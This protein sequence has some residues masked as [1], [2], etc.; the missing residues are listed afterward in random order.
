MIKTQIKCAVAVAAAFF[1][2]GNVKAQNTGE[3]PNISG[4]SSG[5]KTYTLGN[6]FGVGTSAPKA[7][8]EVLYCPQSLPNPFPGLIVTSTDACMG[9]G[10][11]T[12]G[13]GTGGTDGMAGADG[14]AVPYSILGITQNVPVQFPSGTGYHSINGSSQAP[15]I[16]ARTQSPFSTFGTTNI[17]GQETPRFIVWPNG[18]TGINTA[19]P[20]AALDVM[21]TTPNK[22]VAIFGVKS[23]YKASNPIGN[24]LVDE[25]YSKHIDIYSQ[26][27]AGFANPLTQQHDQFIGFTDGRNT[28]GFNLDGGLV[29]APLN[30]SAVSGGIRIDKSGAVQIPNLK[31]DGTILTG[32][33][34]LRGKLTCNGFVS[35]PKWWPDFV[36]E[37]N[38]HLM[39][40]DSVETYIQTHKHLPGVPSQ[41]QILAEGQ[42]I[43]AIQ[44]LQMQKIEELMLYVLEKDKQLN[45][46]KLQLEIMAKE[47]ERLS[48][49]VKQNK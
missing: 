39:S 4:S 36:F 17:V 2:H 27:T 35:K 33:L 15:L 23:Q 44:Q 7:W 32:D 9:G 20:R 48:L 6:T 12:G 8:A 3:W 37:K 19:T 38:Y 43:A 47:I 34:E 49:A 29:I 41:A 30:A 16:I 25:Y 13:P 21:G 24:L 1:F 28:G 10:T 11:G 18:N 40:L 31:L 45:E 22:P 42:D 46:Q 5:I 14:E 26:I